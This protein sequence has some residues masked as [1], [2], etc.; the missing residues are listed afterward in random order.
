MLL[1]DFF[2]GAIKEKTVLQQCTMDKYLEFFNYVWYCDSL[3]EIL[4]INSR[5]SVGVIRRGHVRG[6]KVQ[7]HWGLFSES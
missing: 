3:A 6:R 2:N 1:I 7:G 4:D 5:A